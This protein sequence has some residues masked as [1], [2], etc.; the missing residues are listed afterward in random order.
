MPHEFK[1]FEREPQTQAGGSRRGVPPR[2]NTAAGVL[3]PP[4]APQRWWARWVPLSNIP[5]PT[6]KLL[7]AVVLLGFVLSALALLWLVR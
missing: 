7:A 6:M 2:K 5:R 1:A 3:D 4:R